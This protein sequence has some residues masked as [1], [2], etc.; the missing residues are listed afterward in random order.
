M[1]RTQWQKC[2]DDAAVEGNLKCP[3]VAGL[4]VLCESNGMNSIALADIENFFEKQEMPT[5]SDL[6]CSDLFAL[7]EHLGWQSDHEEDD[8]ADRKKTTDEQNSMCADPILEAIAQQIENKDRFD[9]KPEQVEDEEKKNEAM[10]ICACFDVLQTESVMIQS[11]Q[12]AM[13]AAYMQ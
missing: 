6:G 2:F 4:F 7:L 13:F 3:G 11:K 8:D 5:D 9:V 10:M 1:S 12:D